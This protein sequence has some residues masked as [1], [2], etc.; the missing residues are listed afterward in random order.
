M[1]F[2]VQ[3]GRYRLRELFFRYAP[4]SL[5]KA[6]NYNRRYG[7]S[8]SEILRY[9]MFETRPAKIKYPD[10]LCRNTSM[11]LDKTRTERQ[12]DTRNFPSLF[13]FP[14]LVKYI[15]QKA[16]FGQFIQNMLKYHSLQALFT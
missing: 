11:C 1:P 9:V 7:K 16:C 6:Y 12:Y 15:L 5:S 13:I 2:R 10:I 4:E 8:R 3:T 14:G